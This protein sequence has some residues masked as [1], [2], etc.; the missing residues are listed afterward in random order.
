MHSLHSCRPLLAPLLL[1]VGCAAGSNASGGG[2]GGDFDGGGARDGTISSKSS[3]QASIEV[4][5]STCAG[6][7]YTAPVTVGGSQT[8]ELIVD[9]GSGALAVSSTD[10]T[11][12]MAAGITAGYSPASSATALGTTGCQYGSGS[13]SGEAYS[14][15]VTMGASP[16][17]TTELA[18]IKKQTGLIT[19]QDDCDFNASDTGVY[20]GLVGFGPSGTASAVPHTSVFFDDLVSAGVPN[21][22]SLELCDSKG[23]LWLGGYDS[24]AIAGR[25]AP[26]YIPMLDGALA[27]YYYVVHL[28]T[29][30]VNGTTATVP[31]ASYAS[32]VL[33][34]GTSMFILQASAF[35][36]IARAIES[37]SAF[38][39][40]LAMGDA[41]AGGGGSSGAFFDTTDCM[42]LQNV[43][44]LNPSSTFTK[45]YLDSTLP[46]L[47][48]TL[49]TGSQTVT[50][51]APATESY[52]M[53]M[54]GQWCQAMCGQTPS[55]DFPMAGIIGAEVLKS[56]IVVF[57]R[58]K[59]RK[60]VV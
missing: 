17:A 41:G 2:S 42:S 22:F 24:A 43:G 23:T 48:L 4:P 7:V 60:S 58:A 26:S 25:V 32:S 36:Q 37:D 55:L 29:V 52:L 54:Q 33:D 5:L 31:T 14:D 3:G 45:A 18:A 13:W 38:Q 6:N 34:T 39:T 59:D 57:D 44:C 47:T 15:K 50:L 40:V 35:E 16:A 1:C 21:V 46:P 53:Y 12:C 11:S 27:P 49:G 8:F 56:T 30:A 28:A 9:T 20:A 10:C 51:T 19:N